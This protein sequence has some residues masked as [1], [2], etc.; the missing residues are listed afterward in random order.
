VASVTLRLLY[1]ADDAYDAH[2]RESAFAHAESVADGV[3][4][5]KEL[6]DERLVDD[7]DRRRSVMC[8]LR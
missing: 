7:N 3:L 8:R 2:L 5:G 4:A 1:V 6:V